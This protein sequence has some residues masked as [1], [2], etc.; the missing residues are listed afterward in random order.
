MPKFKN[1]SSFGD[2][3]SPLLGRIVKA[4]EVA[5]VTDA[6]AEKLSAQPD[7][8]QAVKKGSDA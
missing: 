1:V 4:G 3:D 2:L 7:V 8:W 6:Q 5:E